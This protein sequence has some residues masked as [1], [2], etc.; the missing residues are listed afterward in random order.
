MLPLTDAGLGR[1]CAP[2]AP[3]RSMTDLLDGSDALAAYQRPEL[4]IVT[5]LPRR[6]SM[7]AVDASGEA[8]FRAA[9]AGDP[10]EQIH[11]ATYAVTADALAARSRGRRRHRQPA[12]TQHRHEA[13]VRDLR[14]PDPPRLESLTRD[15]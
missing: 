9:A 7:S 14:A 3:A 6:S 1:C 8:L 13:R 4:D 10:T 2:D 12:S 11:L 15:L 5:Y